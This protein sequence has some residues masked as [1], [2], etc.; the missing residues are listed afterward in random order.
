[1]RA[2]A[3]GPEPVSLIGAS[4]ERCTATTTT[5][6]TRTRFDARLRPRQRGIVLLLHGTY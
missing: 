2:I 3:K 6:R 1:M 4:P 5:T